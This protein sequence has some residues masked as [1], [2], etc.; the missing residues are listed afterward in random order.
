MQAVEVLLLELLLLELEL[1]EL[2]LLLEELPLEVEVVLLEPPPQAATT[3]AALPESSQPI[4]WRRCCSCWSI[5]S[6]SCWRPRSWSW[7]RWSLMRVTPKARG[8]LQRRV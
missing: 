2:E 5:F 3:A 6:R 8:G 4:I 1:L 7:G